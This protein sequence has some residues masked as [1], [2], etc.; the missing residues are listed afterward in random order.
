MNSAGA[1]VVEYY[2]YDASSDEPSDAWETSI[3]VH[4]NDMPRFA[5]EKLDRLYGS[6]FSTLDQ[7]KQDDAIAGTSTYVVRTNGKITTLLMFRFEQGVVKVLNQLIA[8]DCKELERF[9][10]FIF[11]KY[12]FVSAISLTAI[13]SNLQ[14]LSYPYQQ[15]HSAEDI[16]AT[17][18]ESGDKL[19][20]LLGK[21]M[22][23]T[24]K[25]Y[26][27]KVKRTFPSF[28]F[29]VY[30]DD[31]IDEQLAMEIY[32]FHK[33]RMHI[34]N[35][36]SK[37]S[38]QRFRKF[39]ELARWRGMMTVATIDGRPCAGL[40][41]WRVD[42]RY[43]MRIIAHDP[44]FDEYKLGTIS[45]YHTM[46]EC[47][48]RGGKTFHFLSG[49]MQYKYRFLGVEQDFDR[50]VIYRSRTAILRNL[51]LALRTASRGTIRELLLWLQ[52]AERKD[53]RISRFAVSLVQRWRMVKRLKTRFRPLSS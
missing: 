24:V 12:P 23:E 51:P 32:A 9:S 49:R 28:R 7:F 35:D 47:T 43:F 48:A 19:L 37:V 41:C 8:I 34:K 45:C 4:E 14:R 25:R 13:Q 39:I 16:V 46:R 29:D 17:L 22:R 5:A 26:T 6:I 33:A 36:I 40:I 10:T 44:Q 52:N 50:V 53:D 31:E 3:V 20:S 1:R 18:P 27:N 21:N 11:T 38:E 30:V 2:I 42:D 15:F